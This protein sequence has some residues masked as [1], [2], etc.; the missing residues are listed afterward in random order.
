MGEEATTEQKIQIIDQQDLPS[1]TAQNV[2]NAFQSTISET[3]WVNVF[4]YAGERVLE[5]G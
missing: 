5:A 4:Q 1:I 2:K 3:Y